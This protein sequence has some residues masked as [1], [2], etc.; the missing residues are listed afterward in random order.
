MERL[1]RSGNSE[2]T[3][4]RHQADSLKLVEDFENTAVELYQT[5]L[6]FQIRFMRQNSISWAKRYGR[7]IFKADDWNSL[8]SQIKVLE[9]KCTEIAKV[10]SLERIE[11]ALQGSEQIMQ[12]GLQKIQQELEKTTRGIEKQTVMQSAWRQTDEERKCVQLFRQSNPYENQK[13]RTPKAVLGTGKWF[14][15]N[16]KFIDWREHEGPDLLWLSAKPGSGKSVLART[17]IDDGLLTLSH[18]KQSAVCYFFFKDISP[19]QRSAFSAISAILHQL[20]SA[21]PSLVKHAVL[22]YNVNG[23]ELLHLFDEMFHILRQAAADPD[24]GQVVCVLDALDECNDEDRSF[25]V[26]AIT[27]F[28][29]EAKNASNVGDQPKLKF[30]MTSRP[31]S[32]IYLDLHD[33]IKETPSIHLSGDYESEKIKDE[34][35]HV[36]EV[37]IPKLAA[38]KGFDEEATKYLVGKLRSVQNRTYLWLSLIM[39]EIRLSDRPSNK[40]ELNKIISNLPRSVIDA[41][42]SILRRCRHP[43]LAR[44]LLHIILAAREP[45]AVDDMKI[46]TALASDLG[47]RSYE[48]IGIER[49]DAFE[50]RI[51]NICG[52]ITVDGGVVLLIHQ[53]AKEFLL[54]DGNAS[55]NCGTWQFSFRPLDSEILLAKICITLLSFT[56]FSKSP[57][58]IDT[59]DADE[60]DKKVSQYAR[61]H[62]FL[63]Y[64]SMNWVDHTQRAEIDDDPKWVPSML[65]LCRADSS[66]CRTWYTIYQR[67]PESRLPWKITSLNLAAE[68]KFTNVLAS[69]LQSRE[70][71]NEPDGHGATPLARSIGKSRRAVELLLDANADVNSGEWDEPWYEEIDET[72]SEIEVKPFAGTPLTMA[73]WDGDAKMVQYLI[74]RGAKMDFPPSAYLTPLGAAYLRCSIAPEP[75]SEELLRLLVS[76]G[77]NVC[78]ETIREDMPVT[79]TVLHLAAVSEDSSLLKVLLDSETADVNFQL[80]ETPS[81]VQ[82]KDQSI[83]ENQSSVHES[84]LSIRMRSLSH[85][86]SNPDRTRDTRDCAEDSNSEGDEENDNTSMSGSQNP[87]D[88]S[89]SGSGSD[90]NSSE[91]S[92][93][94]KRYNYLIGATPLHLAVKDGYVDNVR[95]ILERGTTPGIKN[96][97]GHTA[98]DLALRLSLVAGSPAS[99]TVV[100]VK[101]KLIEMLEQYGHVSPDGKEAISQCL[102]FCV[103]TNRVSSPGPYH[104]DGV[105]PSP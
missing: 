53:T 3:G 21:F 1:T 57:L 64:A 77:A 98:M 66:T 85:D 10:L 59:D 37:D 74:D 71:P 56:C 72:N 67:A 91:S 4:N 60:A 38:T 48:E 81:G 78:F 34:I 39:E 27:T 20:F 54:N 52:L 24:I 14:L 69:L 18:Q 79:M 82:L 9:A 35:D 5:I 73:V 76:L 36:I 28:Y 87:D 92:T 17:L 97:H 33:V 11:R 13:N 31:Y 49:S 95:L 7:D 29:Y 75:E 22:S 45:L 102:L 80:R 63:R 6:E 51:K 94:W 12:Q 41:F 26:K 46:A 105:P 93:S 61:D 100:P 44:Q 88:N 32:H 65:S 43:E 2:S 104:F 70:D 90:D 40:R 86:G 99:E 103:V 47:Y 84:G 25:L 55:Q 8:T 68:F 62:A 96:S 30:L 58:T 15:E 101:R 42:D 19:Y 89:S 50:M 23:K 16:Q 83:D